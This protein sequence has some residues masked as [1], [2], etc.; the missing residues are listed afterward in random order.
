MALFKKKVTYTD[1]V[2][3]FITGLIQAPVKDIGSVDTDG[4][5][6][7]K[8]HERITKGLLPFSLVILLLE[9]VKTAQSGTNPHITKR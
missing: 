6:T 4:N 3:N 2:G 7:S 5:I 9:L 1:Y 8:E